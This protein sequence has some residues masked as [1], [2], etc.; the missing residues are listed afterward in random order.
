[1]MAQYISYSSR[2]GGGGGLTSLNG[3]TGAVNLVAGSGISITPAGQNITIAATGGGGTVTSV[4]LADSTGLFNITGSPVTTSGTLTLASFQSQ[5]QHTFF[6]APSGSAGAPT[7]RTIVQSDLSGDPN[8]VAFFNS[9][10]AL[11]DDPNVGYFP[12][13]TQTFPPFATRGFY[14]DSDSINVAATGF[15]FGSTDTATD[16]FTTNIGIIT[17]S[18]SAIGAANDTG[19]IV[20]STGSVSDATATAKSGALN[21]QTG[22]S[23]GNNSGGL[24]L[25]TGEV[26]AGH[27]GSVFVRTGQA[28]TS[29]GT[30]DMSIQTGD[31]NSGSTGEIRLESG[32]STSGSTGN[33]TLTSGVAGVS[34]GN[35][36]ALTGDSVEDSGVITIK[37]GDASGSTFSSGPLNLITGSADGASGGLFAQTGASANGNTGDIAFSTGTASTVNSGSVNFTT[38]DATVGNSGV[39]LF[40]TGTAG[41]ARGQLQFVDGSEGTAGYVWTSTDTTGKGAWMPAGSAS[42]ITATKSANYTIVSED[43]I[44]C[45]TS[46]GAFTITLPSPTNGRLIRLLDIT[47][48]FEANN[49][50][51]APSGAEKI[52]GLAANRIL[53]GNWESAEI[54]SNGT[55]WF[56]L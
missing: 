54:L 51:V 34:S 3:E 30:G 13:I 6:A 24:N 35:L 4:A 25:F 45:N 37:T 20:F 23:A 41:T 12:T 21:L 56:I 31:A 36:N 22:N 1:M 14:A 8:S 40:Q 42:L 2:N 48:S 7:F 17:G 29:G 26:N 32:A 33:A 55:D 18:N 11:A 53:E 50:T 38:G 16:S 52:S 19:G 47:G 10:G 27:S 28:F 15:I 46:G 49:L 39:L 5:A 44:F 9:S 43:V